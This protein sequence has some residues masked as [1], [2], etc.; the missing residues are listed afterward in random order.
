MITEEEIKAECLR[1]LS[2]D[3][4]VTIDELNPIAKA[5]WMA[6]QKGFIE[7]S[8]FMMEKD[9]IEVVVCRDCLSTGITDPDCICCYSK[10]YPTVTDTKEVC[11][12]CGNIND[13]S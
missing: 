9:K 6:Y 13:Y 5:T 4:K 2:R 12:C 1:I 8:E 10:N 3:G 7:G 11:K